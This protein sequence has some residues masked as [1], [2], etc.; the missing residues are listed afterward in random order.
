MFFKKET[1]QKKPKYKAT[2]KSLHSGN[3][4]VFAVVEPTEALAN[5]L[6]KGEDILE[7]YM[8]TS[9]VPLSEEEQL[10]LDF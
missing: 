9:I 8:L 6:Q 1:E 7:M 2:Y 3:T 5:F 10:K 4:K